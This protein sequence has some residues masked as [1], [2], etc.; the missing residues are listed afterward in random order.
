M[1][2]IQSALSP[3]RGLNSPPSV[4]TSTP[5]E[6]QLLPCHLGVFRG[7]FWGLLIETVGAALVYG[8]ILTLRMAFR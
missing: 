3:A 7:L 5:P 6:P 8:A 2:S 1:T 4:I